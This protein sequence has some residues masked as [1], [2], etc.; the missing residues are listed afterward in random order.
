M[1]LQREID[2][3]SLK[4]AQQIPPPVMAALQASIAS[5]RESGTTAHAL[6]VGALAP[7][8][9]MP[10]ASGVPVTLHGL[11]RHG[12]LIVSFYRGMWC[13]YCSM[14][15]RAY[16][17]IL[18]DIRA[19]GGDF[20]AI[21]PQTPDHSRATAQKNVLDFEV[22]SDGGNQVARAYGIAYSTPDIVRKI[23]ASFGA[24][25]ATFNGGS[26]EQ[27]PIPATYVI[28]QDRHIRLAGTNPDFRIRLEPAIA[29]EALRELQGRPSSLE[30]SMLAQR[31][32]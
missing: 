10:N 28:G 26:D 5:V 27:L 31:T 20:V 30:I 24:E 19:A 29:L 12:P 18:G 32:R 4:A 17:R 11:L 9:T 2:T 15:L 16:Q 21:S 8:F 22:L 3:F 13:P 14:E 6:G 23:T 25:I 7:H 1:T